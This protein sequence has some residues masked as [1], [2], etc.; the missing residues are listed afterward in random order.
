MSSHISQ[1]KLGAIC[2]SVTIFAAEPVQYIHE[3][4]RL[5]SN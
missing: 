2:Y 4:V 1:A 5:T 3:Y